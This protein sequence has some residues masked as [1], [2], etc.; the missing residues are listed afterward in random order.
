MTE[1][2]DTACEVMRRSIAEL[3]AP[4][5]RGDADLVAGWVRN[6]TPES[7]RAWLRPGNSMLVAVEGDAMLAV[8]SVT[9][10]GTITLNYVSPDAR[11]HGV[12][13]AMI[14]AL[15]ARAIERGNRRCTLNSTV[16]A[17]RFY[18]S[19][20]YVDSNGTRTNR[21]AYRGTSPASV[22][23]CISRCCP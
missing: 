16:T 13:K 6:K 23:R 2:A 7:F 20:G 18:Q 9:D 8:G 21:S 15:E 14:A 5:H 4:D 22:I 1:D 19:V 11:F 3:C 17:R 12:S 10:T